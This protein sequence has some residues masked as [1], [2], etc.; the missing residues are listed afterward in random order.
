MTATRT[1]VAV[2][3]V[4][5]PDG[6]DLTDPRVQKRVDARVRQ[7]YGQSAVV[8]WPRHPDVEDGIAPV[9]PVLDARPGARTW[10]LGPAAKAA[11]APRV[12]AQAEQQG[13]TLVA[14]DVFRREAVVAQIDVETRIVRDRLAALLRCDP[15]AVEVVCHRVWD[16]GEERLD[17][18]VVLRAPEGAT[19]GE[20]R[21]QVWADLIPALGGTGGWEVVDDPVT[22]Q[23]RLRYGLP[24]SLP[25]AVGMSEVLPGSLDTSAW[26]DLAFG[27]DATNRPARLDLRLAVHCLIVGPTGSGKSVFLRTHAA[28]ALAH[29]HALVVI[30]AIK[31]GLDF[32][33]FKPWCT[34]FADNGVPAAKAAIER[35][36][37]E[38]RRRKALLKQYEAPSWID[39]PPDVRRR[40]RIQPMTVLFDEFMSACIASPV[41]K[42]LD[43][44]DP[45]V[46]EANR[47]N[48][49]KA[50]ILALV[51][52]I[53]RE[54]RFTGIFLAVAM[55]RP[56]ASLLPGFGEV[57]SNLP[58]AVQLIKP[59]SMPA[60][61]TLRM[62]FPG[63][64]TQAAADTIVELDD[65]RSLGL[66]LVAAEGGDVTG[67]RVA[68]GKPSEIP[69]LL[70]DLGIPRVTEPWVL[71]D[72]DAAS[73]AAPVR[74]LDTM[75]PSLD[76]LEALSDDEDDLWS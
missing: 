61:E 13:L 5:L 17:Q 27:L 47:L 34:A 51:G 71:A 37:E 48:G 40:E 73:G 62:V 31:D 49:D 33:A 36:Y 25:I 75:T 10:Q 35:V 29:G 44:D 18:V 55:Q 30:D 58:G 7:T 65:G 43:K 16:E 53:A 28:Q 42:G 1:G 74:D 46:E 2:A 68:F 69:L 20:K 24:R 66:A 6:T 14:F 76:D 19:S 57:R 72:G 45:L 52:K 21:R 8:A 70:D 38:G 39:L 64:Q 11:D 54:L 15:W 23:V 67:F 50:T 41:P 4:E 32:V 26:H 60:Q 59:G 12:A 3:Y 9:V 56:D 63:D 22:G